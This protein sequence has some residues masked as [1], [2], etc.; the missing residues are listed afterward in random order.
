MNNQVCVGSFYGGEVEPGT[1]CKS[2]CPPV[3]NSD[4]AIEDNNFL[5]ENGAG[6]QSEIGVV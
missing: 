6:C 1:F 2:E 3:E 4:S 5:V